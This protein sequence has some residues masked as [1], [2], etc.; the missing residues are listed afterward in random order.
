MKIEKKISVC[1]KVP[2]A[3]LLA[4]ETGLPKGRIKDAMNK[5][6]VVHQRGRQR[7]FLRRATGQLLPGDRV[8]IHY[9]EQI[10][11]LQPPPLILVEDRHD[12]SIWHKAAGMLSQSSPWGDH[13]SVLRQAELQLSPRRDCLSVHRLDRETEG[14]IIVAHNGKAAAALSRMFQQHR[15]GKYYRALVKG[16]TG[17]E[18]RIERKLDGKAASTRFER[19]SYDDDNDCSLL[20]IRLDSGRKHQIRRHLADARHPLLGDPRYG[21]GNKNT[22]GLQ[23]VAYRLSFICPLTARNVDVKIETLLS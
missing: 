7:K 2:A 15:V 22:A 18:G 12:Y 19:L 9:D 21:K 23:L 20:D 6:A 10:L 5:G 16:R 17:L 1:E 11:A 4:S 14:L 8:E 13:N 3:E